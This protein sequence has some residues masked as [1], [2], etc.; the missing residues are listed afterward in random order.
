MGQTSSILGSARLATLCGNHVT[1]DRQSTSA[2]SFASSDVDI[3]GLWGSGTPPE[4]VAVLLPSC[5]VLDVE[6]SAVPIAGV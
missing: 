6:L 2:R 1:V 5:S 3:A 4:T